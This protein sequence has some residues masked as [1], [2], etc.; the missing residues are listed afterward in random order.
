MST[1]STPYYIEDYEPVS[2]YLS[3]SEDYEPAPFTQIGLKND[4]PEIGETSNC[5]VVPTR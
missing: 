4:K 2:A 3:G 1:S 5:K